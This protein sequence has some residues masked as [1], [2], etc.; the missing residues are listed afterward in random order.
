MVQ[1]C[2]TTSSCALFLL[3]T[4]IEMFYAKIARKTF[5]WTVMYDSSF[6]LFNKLELGIFQVIPIPGW[7]KFNLA[8]QIG[9]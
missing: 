4:A 9:L 6:R 7:V 5:S 2:G 3:D 8:K 1:L